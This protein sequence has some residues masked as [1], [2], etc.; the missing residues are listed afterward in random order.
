MRPFFLTRPL[1]SDIDE[2]ADENGGCEDICINTYGAFYCYCENYGYVVHEN[3]KNCTGK[4]LI[5]QLNSKMIVD[6]L[7]LVYHSF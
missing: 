5:F 6:H 1:I 2:C 4:T 7:P 3:G